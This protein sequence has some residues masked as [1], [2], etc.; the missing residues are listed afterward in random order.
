MATDSLAKL[1]VLITRPSGRGRELCQQL[2]E[3]GA[4]VLHIP[5]LEIAPLDATA[6][7]EA[8]L[9]ET[10]RRAKNAV[11]ELDR[12]NALIFI[13]VN[14]VHHGMALVE[15][16]WPQMPAGQEYFAI[17]E[18]TAQA[19]RDH[20]LSPTAA[21]AAMNSEA[22]LAH[23][24]LK[25]LPHQRVAIFRGLGG[26]ETL[27][28]TLTA[29]GARVDYIECYQRL[30]PQLEA[31]DLIQRLAEANINCS[32]VN[33]GESLENLSAL[34]PA[35]HA[36]YSQPVILPSDRVAALA[37]KLG[38]ARAIVAENASQDATLKALAKLAQH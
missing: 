1:K 27:A 21:G 12:Y 28:E 14:A 30:T 10:M 9:C 24:S 3:R 17:G 35:G 23:P 16:Y 31:Q 4:T 22:L 7:S 32:V 20:H 11:L 6:H 2:R 36:L 33:S 18:A 38:Y 25:H 5:M 8:T 15:E 19:L 34:L 29:R 26:R 37:R 13:S